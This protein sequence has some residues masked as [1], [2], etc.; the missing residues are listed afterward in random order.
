[1]I[2]QVIETINGKTYLHL[3]VTF[4]PR[5][6][7]NTYGVNASAGWA[8]RMMAAPKGDM[9]G[10]MMGGKAPMGGMMNKAPHTFDDL[11]GSEGRRGR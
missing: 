8:N 6:V 1:M 3:R 2:E 4:D 5:F 7:D 10:G 9:P 11:V